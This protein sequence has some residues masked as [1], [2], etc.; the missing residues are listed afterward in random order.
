MLRHTPLYQEHVK[1][2]AYFVN[3]SG[4]EMPLRYTSQI[5][6]HHQVRQ[7]VGIFDVSHM[8][9]IDVTGKDAFI[10]LR[11]L[12]ANDIAKLKDPGCALYTCM[13]NEIGGIIDDLI[14]YYIASH[15]YRLIVNAGTRQKNL[16]W[17]KRQSRSLK[18]I[19]NECPQ[20]CILAVQGP[21]VFSII[22]PVFN[23]SIAA[24]LISLKPFQFVLSKDLLIAR[25]GY[26][27]ENGFEIVVPDKELPA[28]WKKLINRGAKP[29]GLGARDTLRLEAGLNLYGTDMDETTSPLVSNLAW[30]ISL[31]DPARHFIGRSALKKQLYEGVKEQL[32]GLIMEEPGVLRNHQKVWLENNKNGEITSGGFSP[33]LGYAIA[34]ARLPVEIGSAAYIERRGK[35]IPVKIIKPPFIRR[36]KK[37]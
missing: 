24:E 34:L 27:G 20:M 28:L 30:T 16:A 22:K 1:M 32:V 35:Y 26:T 12:L 25:T 10:F 4:W 2:K 31:N 23:Q 17:I 6:E 9:V 8:G 13:L 36:G 37:I 7:H 15:H 3:F 21:A 33:T 18:V 14:I 5:K 11:Y 19:V 29:C